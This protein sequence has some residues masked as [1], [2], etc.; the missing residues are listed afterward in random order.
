MYLLRK[1]QDFK[2]TQFI[3]HRGQDMEYERASKKQK[4]KDESNILSERQK[5][6]SKPPK[7]A[8]GGSSV[9]PPHVQH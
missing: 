2:K 5:Q 3:S 6:E 9:T 7:L 1:P 8:P 4:A